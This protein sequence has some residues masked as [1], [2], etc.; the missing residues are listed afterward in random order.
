MSATAQSKIDATI[1]RLDAMLDQRLRSEE[2]EQARADASL[3]DARRQRQRA[4][5]EARRVIQAVYA[6]AYR[7]F[8]TEVPAPVDDESPMSFRKR[9]FNRLARRLPSGHDLEDVR[10]DDLGSQPVVFDN[11]EAMLL[12][13]AKAEGERPSEANLP[14]DGSLVARHRTDSATGE[15]MTEFFGR[16]SFIKDMTR[17]GRK[18]QAIIDRNSAQAIWGRIG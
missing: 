6:D 18:V 14:S 17:P 15:R 12:D 10:A 3:E 1:S 5:A 4:N 8:G 2:A 7:S 9:L 16:S 13:A 11:F